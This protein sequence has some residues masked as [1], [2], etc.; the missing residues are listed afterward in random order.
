MS[1]PG[2]Y[3]DDRQN[4]TALNHDLSD[5]S[6]LKQLAFVVTAAICEHVDS[7]QSPATP[8][9]TVSLCCLSEVETGTPGNQANRTEYKEV[10]FYSEGI[11]E[12]EQI[13]E[14]VVQA[15]PLK[16][17]GICL[18]GARSA[19]SELASVLF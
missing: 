3:R 7:V 13:P 2:G 15:P 11:T 14:A 12:L 9:I 18:A 1:Q 10:F 16:V 17:F 19:N 6:P 4:G 5:Q 8:S